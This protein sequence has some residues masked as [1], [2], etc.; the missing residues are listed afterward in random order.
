VD[1][2]SEYPTIGPFRRSGGV[3]FGYEN[4]IRLFKGV[5]KRRLIKNDFYRTAIIE[6]KLRTLTLQVAICYVIMGLT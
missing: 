6:N 4:L 3:T 2:E 5:F 1:S